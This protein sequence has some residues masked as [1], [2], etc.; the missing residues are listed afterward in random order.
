LTGTYPA[1]LCIDIFE[2]IK[3]MAVRVDHRQEEPSSFYWEDIINAS[4]ES[5]LLTQLIS[6]VEESPS[7]VLDYARHLE[8]SKQED[9]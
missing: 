7:F 8:L 9:T 6:L 1:W 3:Q 4:R 2:F 5:Q